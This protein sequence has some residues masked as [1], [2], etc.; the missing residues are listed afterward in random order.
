VGVIQK[1]AA[2]NTLVI[3]LGLGIGV[4]SRLM[5]P[6]ILSQEQIG[7]LALLDSVSNIFSTIFTLGFFQIASRMF[8]KFRDD[9]QGHHGFLMFGI[10]I[11]LVGIV[12]GLSGFYVLRP[13]LFDSQESNGLLS[14]FI[15]LIMPI[16]LFRILY[17]NMDSYMRM[18]F[19]SVL[20]SWLESFLLKLLLLCSLLLFW[21]GALSFTAMA[22]MY[23]VAFCIPGLIMTVISFS[24][25]KKIRMPY[26]KSFYKTHKRELY[27]NGIFGILTYASGAIVL[28]IVQL[29]MYKMMTV[30]VVGVYSILFFAG[31]I[32]GVPF[33]GVKRIAVPVIAESWKND[34]VKNIEDVYQKSSITGMLIGFYLLAVGW[35]CLEHVLTYIPQY[36]YGR[37]VFLFIGIAQLVDM[38][39]GVSPAIIVTSAKYKW[40]TYFNILLALVVVL[41]NFIFIPKFGI[42][43]AGLATMCSMILINIAR[44]V[45]VS[46]QFGIQP[47]SKKT[48][49]AMLIGL[50]F[51]AIAFWNPLSFHP[52]VNV[53]IYFVLITAAY[54]PLVISLNL[55][56]DINRFV[57][58]LRKKVLG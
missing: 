25:T 31:L 20:G 2:Q 7:V 18:L 50:G 43:G 36:A 48:L 5:M 44:Y 26:P 53:A 42:V 22:Y 55:S 13:C 40:A 30:E 23:I 33:R 16:I 6:L 57:S 58:G 19:S 37:Y 24:K 11:S 21:S 8:P 10:L 52:L 51:L 1:Q 32:V 56:P 38:S 34:D 14:G 12:L 45:F 46:T 28:S 4:V 47:F 3:F 9:E 15:L 29:M 27:H 17:K 39:G 49:Q 35:A 54:W 41:T